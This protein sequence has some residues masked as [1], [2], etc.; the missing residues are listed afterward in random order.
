MIKFVTKVMGMTTIFTMMMVLY[1]YGHVQIF[2]V[3]YEIN[4]QEKA[5]ETKSK[6]FRELRFEVDQLKAPA[7]LEQK[8]KELEL[9]L[10]L[11]KNVEMIEIPKIP[12]MNSIPAIPIEPTSSPVFTF[13]GQWVK[14]AQAKMDR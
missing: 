3:S 2:H 7:L 9:D 4:A 8:L 11:P 1:V 10:D 13:L 12:T 14:V 5:L 6:S